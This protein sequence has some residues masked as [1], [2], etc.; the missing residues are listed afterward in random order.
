M[1]NLANKQ[2]SGTPRPKQKSAVI[3]V[4]T[5]TDSQTSYKNTGSPW[6]EGPGLKGFEH[7]QGSPAPRGF[8]CYGSVCTE[9]K[10]DYPACPRVTIWAA[11][12]SECSPLPSLSLCFYTPWQ[13]KESLNKWFRDLAAKVSEKTTFP[14]MWK[15]HLAYWLRLYPCMAPLIASLLWPV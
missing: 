5:A 15:D 1:L 7:V 11:F 2:C 4:I 10:S 12:C 13:Q 9:E 14:C 3:R 6:A 8:A